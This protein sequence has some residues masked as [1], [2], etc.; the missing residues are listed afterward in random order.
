MLNKN[1]IQCSLFGV[2]ISPLPFEIFSLCFK[3]P[4]MLNRA[5]YKRIHFSLKHETMPKNKQNVFKTSNI[6]P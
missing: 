6:S 4:F 1:I 3:H 2:T 5:K